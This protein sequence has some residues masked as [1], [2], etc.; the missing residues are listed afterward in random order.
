MSS[1][2]IVMCELLVG[3]GE[4]TVLDVTDTDERL[5]VT[6]ETRASRPSCP[7]CESPVVVKDRDLVVLVDLPCFGRPAVL[8]WRKVRWQCRQGCGSFT[9]VAPQIAAPRLRLMDRAGPLGNRSGGPSRPLRVGGGGRSGLWVAC[10]DG[11]GGRLRPGPGGRS[12]PVR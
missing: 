8:V 2:P 7:R 6:V 11:R 4:V 9:E 12:G 1:D 5:R 3:L 10:G